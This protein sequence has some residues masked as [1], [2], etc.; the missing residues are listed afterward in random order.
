[1]HGS[2]YHSIAKH[3][4]VM[5]VKF[6]GGLSMLVLRNRQLITKEKKRIKSLHFQ[7]FSKRVQ[8]FEKCLMMDPKK[9]LATLDL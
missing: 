3:F 8:I 9:Q 2:R 6:E 5:H 4:I 7:S 1:M